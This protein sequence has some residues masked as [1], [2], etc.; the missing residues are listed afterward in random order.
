[1]ILEDV[2]IG[3]GDDV[4]KPDWIPEPIHELAFRLLAPGGVFVSNTL[5]EHNR[6]A[7]TMREHFDRIVSI[8]TEDYDNQVLVAANGDLTG[9]GLRRCVAESPVLS[10]SL[11]ILSFRLR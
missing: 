6:V 7:R 8:E 2:F 9:A 4:R 5:D 3:K 1:V 10:A 11:P